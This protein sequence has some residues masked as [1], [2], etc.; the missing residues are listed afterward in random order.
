MVCGEMVIGAR[1]RDQSDALGNVSLPAKRKLSAAPVNSPLGR[2][3]RKV[4]CDGAAV[5]LCGVVR[6]QFKMG[7]VL[8]TRAGD[9]NCTNFA[10]LKAR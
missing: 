10:I 3:W 8:L 9:K 5:T 7:L 2:R 4:A 1:S 6:F